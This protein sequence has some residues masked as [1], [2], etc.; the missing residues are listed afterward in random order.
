LASVCE[1][2]GFEVMRHYVEAMPEPKIGAYFIT[3]FEVLEHVLDP[4]S[5]LNAIGSQLQ[6]HGLSMLTTL[7]VTGFDIQVLWDRS[8]SVHPPHHINLMSIAGL[9]KLVA[10]S[11]LDL[12]EIATPGELDVDIVRNMA[13][14]QTDIR[15]PRFVSSII[16]GDDNLRNNFQSFLKTNRLSSHVRICARKG[17]H[18]PKD[19][20]DQ[21]VRK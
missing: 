9:E 16:H 12:V 2:R 11:Q 8:K 18:L 20:S 19:A 1:A 21:S 13:N 17:Q 3:A 4:L 7:T 5:F 10:R 14:E 15:L 6:D